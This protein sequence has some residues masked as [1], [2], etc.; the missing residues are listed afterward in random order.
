[1]C[2]STFVFIPDQFFAE[3]WVLD[4]HWTFVEFVLGTEAPLASAPILFVKVPSIGDAHCV[5]F[6]AVQ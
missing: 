4:L 1:M 6:W 5:Y 3:F 2:S